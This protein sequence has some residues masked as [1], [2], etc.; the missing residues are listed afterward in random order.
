L[1]QTL[2]KQ[3]REYD[4]SFVQ[5]QFDASWKGGANTLKMEDLV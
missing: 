4:A 5:K 2:K 3:G 1:Q